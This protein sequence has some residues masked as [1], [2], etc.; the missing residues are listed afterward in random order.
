MDGEKYIYNLYTLFFRNIYI[1][2]TL[3]KYNNTMWIRTR[4]MIII[5]IGIFKSKVNG[6]RQCNNH[7][8]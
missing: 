5:I 8:Q 6:K 1:N 3:Y 2:M 7:S 4:A